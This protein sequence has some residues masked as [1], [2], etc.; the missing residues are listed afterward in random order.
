MT[1]KIHVVDYIQINEPKQQPKPERQPLIGLVLD[2]VNL[3]Q[4]VFVDIGHLAR[5]PTKS[6]LM[7]LDISRL[8]LLTSGFIGLL[9]KI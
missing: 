7:S 9:F 6:N 1:L 3:V 8:S 2:V 5:P 4:S